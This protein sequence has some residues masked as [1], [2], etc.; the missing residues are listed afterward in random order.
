MDHALILS[1][2]ALQPIERKEPP[3]Y[4]MLGRE[5]SVGVQ[6]RADFSKLR[7]ELS[8]TL[9]SDGTATD[10]GALSPPPPPPPPPIAPK[11]ILASQVRRRMVAN[12]T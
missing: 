4:S 7:E 8:R 1:P 9:S 3:R 12:E 11:P 2:I 6:A 5:E 10:E